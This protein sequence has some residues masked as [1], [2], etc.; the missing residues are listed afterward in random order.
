MK[1][2]RLIH[3]SQK[4]DMDKAVQAQST[5]CMIHKMTAVVNPGKIN[6]IAQ[7]RPVQIVYSLSQ[8]LINY[9]CCACYTVTCD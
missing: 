7:L 6:R 1:T 8:E 5:P 3:P 9:V 2:C 4:P